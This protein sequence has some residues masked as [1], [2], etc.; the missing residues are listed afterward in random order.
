MIVVNL[1][2]KQQRHIIDPVILIQLQSSFLLILNH[3]SRIFPM[4]SY[5]PK[6]TYMP[7]VRCGNWGEPFNVKAINMSI[8]I[9]KHP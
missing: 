6:L 1:Q 7:L 8:N 9:Q 3:M 2:L 4:H 5:A